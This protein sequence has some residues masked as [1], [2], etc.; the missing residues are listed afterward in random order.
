[1]FANRRSFNIGDE[2]IRTPLLV[3]S[4]SSRAG[5]QAVTE[6]VKVT[7]EFVGGVILIS[8]YDIKRNRLKQSNVQFATHVFLDSGGY[9]AGADADLSEV[10][11]RTEPPDNWSIAEH[12]DVLTR[13]NF[14]QPTVLVNFDAPDRR[15]KFEKQ[16]ARANRQREKYKFAAHVFLAKPEPNSAQLQR[17]YVD[18]STIIT[19]LGD[20]AEFDIIAVTEKELG[21]SMLTRL[22]N[23]AK[24][25]R[26]LDAKGS[27]QPIHIFGSL[28][29]I[30]CP[31]FFMAGADIFD[32][33][34]WL[35]YGYHK[36]M[37]VYRQNILATEGLQA[38][39]R[40]GALSAHIHVQNYHA[41]GRLGDQ[42]IRFSQTRD[43]G[44]FGQYGHYFKGV[45]ER[46]T[47][48]L[49]E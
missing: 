4:Y 23:T 1:M 17:Y 22:V 3:P 45:A 12:R 2:V 19:H 20:L 6:I 36:G 9:E 7:Q 24:L 33:L 40:D 18:V 14:T 38:D 25:R 35:R 37:A 42:M 44:V 30:A 10:V 43:F 8:A 34:T 26:A 13:W 11:S 29:P 39:T 28:D 48:E 5:G 46:L 41:L 47:A 21:D 31:L 32:G 15:I 49:G 16:V 27:S